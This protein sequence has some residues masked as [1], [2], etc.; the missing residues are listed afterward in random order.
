MI[1]LKDTISRFGLGSSMP[2]ASRPGTTATRAETAL[3]DR[4]ISSASPTTREDFV[5]RAGSNSKRVIT[6]PG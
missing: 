1:A 5:P 6:G 4:A 2:M 3:M